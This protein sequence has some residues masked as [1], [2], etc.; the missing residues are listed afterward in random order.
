MQNNVGLFLAKRAELS[1]EVEGFVDADTGRRFT[2][3]EWNERCNRTAH[4]LL[5]SGVGKGDRVALLQMNSVEY[6]ESFFALAK[7]GAVCV[8]LNWRLV[9]EEL[10]FILRD[11]GARTLIFGGEFLGSVE[12]LQARG[13]G[14]N[15]T[16]IESWVHVGA[17]S[18]RPE[19]AASYDALQ[20][21]ASTA[22][23]PIGADEHDLLYIMYTSGT[24]GL[25]KGAVH[26]HDTATWGVLTIN[27]TADVRHG[28]R[29]LVALPLFHVGALTPIT[30]NV[31]AGVTSVVMRAF[32]P[33]RAWS[34]VADEQVTVMLKVPAMLNFMLQV[35]DPARHSHEQLRWCMSGAAPVPVSLIESYGDMGIE[36]QQVYGLTESCGPACL[37]SSA[38]ALRKAGSTGKAFF[39][40]EVAVVDES[41]S[42]VSPG[43][44]GEVLVRGKHI[45]KQYWNRPEATA[46][47]I[48]D[49]WLHTG[50]IATI[51]D[52]GFIYIQD[53]IKDMIISG[54]ENVYPA[55]IESALM[56][57]DDVVEAGVIGQESE[58][59]GESPVAVVV[60]SREDLSE[61]EVLDFCKDKLARF[62]QPVQVHFVDEIPRNPSGKIL[63]RILR[64]RFPGPAAQ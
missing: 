42:P 14:E 7:I 20:A 32:D 48:R 34:L 15:G 4:A 31:H 19:W 46:E 22:E 41:G 27:A 13:A 6:M 56:R 35:Y 60:R 63:K 3:R 23:P 24:T 43:G 30:S 25:P 26:T 59:W 51:D 1:P 50:D 39:H 52:E 55:E 28:D 58:K 16:A 57:H 11:A 33:E 64:D 61:A 9:P 62:K 38:D 29:Y 44:A 53:R 37:I 17:E 21:G 10:A 12:D 49:G 54:G 8:P 40:T 47:T 2:F 18:E 36:I 45:M 5:S